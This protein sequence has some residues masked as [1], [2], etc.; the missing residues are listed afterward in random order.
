MNAAPGEVRF[1]FQFKVLVPV[2]AAL[3]LLPT[4]TLLIVNRSM[5]EQLQADARQSLAT[6]EALFKQ[7]IERRARDLSVQFRNA[8]NE[9]SY[10]SIAQLAG[11]NDPLARDTIRKFLL[12]RLEAYG[13]EYDAL[14]ITAPDGV[15]L[16]ATRPGTTADPEGWA[17]VAAPFSRA[18]LQG[19]PTSQGSLEF[20]GRDYLL[21]AVP[22]RNA[23]SATL[24]ASLVIATRLSEDFLKD[25]KSLTPAE[26]FLLA[27]P[28]VT[29]STM[30]ESAAPAGIAAGGRDIRQVVL[31]GEHYFALADDFRSS[32]LTGS[33]RY[34]LL[35][36]YEL[37]QRE[38]EHTRATLLGV[39]IA[40][41]LLSGL[42]VWLLIGRVTHPLVELRDNAEAVGRGDFTRRITKFSDDECGAVAVAFNEMT[43][44]LQA[45]RADLEQAVGSLKTAQAQLVQSE[46][47]SA[48]GQFVAG[49]AHELNNPLTSVIGFA[50]LLQH[51]LVDPK[52]QGHVNHIAKAAARCHKIVNN[53]LGFSRQHEPERVS[54]SLNKLTEEVVEILQY[55]LRT[56]NITLV[57]EY[58]PTLPPILGDSHQL[59]QVILNVINNARQALEAFRNDGKI[60]LRTGATASHVW[61]R[62]IDNGPGISRENLNRIFDPFFTT[63][64]QGKGTGLGLSL[65]YG[66]VQEHRGRIRAESQ[67]GTGTEF[68]IELPIA[69][70]PAPATVIKPDSAAPF[71]TPSLRV[72]VVDDEDAIR[73]LVE[74]VLLADGH[75]VESASSGAAALELILNNRYDVIVSDWKMPGLNGINLYQ[76]LQTKDPGAA[77][78][79]LFMTGDVIKQSFQDFLKQN[80]RVCLPKPFALREFRAA[81]AGIVGQGQNGRG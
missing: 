63:K 65:C 9:P 32:A 19:E 61:L 11:S 72:L 45:S 74:E 64:P 62:I 21:V 38:L 48:I 39:S 37:R 77:Q 13:G 7:A 58:A 76:E 75:Q 60:I 79:M 81:I 47:L 3:V 46:K 41:I 34:V 42:V 25:L 69:S 18:A 20:H 12:G 68:I 71:K 15:P 78:R 5:N 51:T 50:D 57:K 6:A 40:G 43:A 73:H 49:V 27:G 35:S 67:P 23:D 26:I 54:L 8:V 17:A 80:T 14:V 4:I 70:E 28:T 59:Q 30:R 52:H 53:L 24:A 66:I 36:S 2:L 10:R 44:N 29:A 22:I 16:V 55:D 1:S 33:F 56:S 31:G